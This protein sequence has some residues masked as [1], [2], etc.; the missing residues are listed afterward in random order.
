[1]FNNNNNNRPNKI[2]QVNKEILSEHVSKNKPVIDGILSLLEQDMPKIDDE[3]LNMIDEDSSLFILDDDKKTETLLKEIEEEEKGRYKYEKN[4]DNII[5]QKEEQ[6]EDEA[7]SSSMN[8]NNPKDPLEEKFPIIFSL[9]TED[10][11]IKKRKKPI[12]VNKCSK[13]LKRY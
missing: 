11:H 12:D 9:L 4:I 1:M 8:F 6:D 7:P 5:N 10:D 2:P 3:I 13:K